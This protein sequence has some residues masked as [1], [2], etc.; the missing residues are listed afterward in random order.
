MREQVER[1]DQQLAAERRQLRR[2]RGEVLVGPE[3]HLLARATGPE[4]S[5]AVSPHDADPGARGRRP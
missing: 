1:A 4:S 3:R 5:P 2:E